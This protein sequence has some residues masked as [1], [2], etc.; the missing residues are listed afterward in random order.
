MALS[1]NWNYP[2]SIRF[3]AGR[4]NELPQACEELGI[5]RPLLVTD[6]VLSA[7][8]ICASTVQVCEEAGLAVT[9]SDQCARN[10]NGADVEA[11]VAAY[12]KAGADGVIAFGG[13][14]A[15]DVAKAVALMVGQD[16]P[17]WDF[18]DIGDNLSL[19]HI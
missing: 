11:G 2:T 4:V 13:G 6:P 9:V 14:A 5:A 15:L 8:P 10:P 17:L 12:R 19:I 3:G 18:E 16:R 7:L 1:G